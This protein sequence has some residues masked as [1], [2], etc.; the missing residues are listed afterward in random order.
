MK[1][2]KESFDYIKNISA[3]FVCFVLMVVVR[4][5]ESSVTGESLVADTPVRVYSVSA[6]D[7]VTV[8]CAY[9]SWWPLLHFIDHK[10]DL[11]YGQQSILVRYIN[12]SE[13]ATNTGAKGIKVHDANILS[14][15]ILFFRC[16]LMIIRWWERKKEEIITIIFRYT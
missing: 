9:F 11:L 8:G 16:H 1:L 4:C 7:R 2:Q 5:D 12:M 3:P 10:F 6:D 15:F 13:K 14:K